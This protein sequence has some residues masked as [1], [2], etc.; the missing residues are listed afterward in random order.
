MRVLAAYISVILIWSTTPLAIKW[1]G[2]G[3][4]YLFGVTGRM[5]IGAIC[6]AMTLLLLRRRVV[7][8]RKARRTYLAVAVQIYAAM[9]VVY[10][11]SQYIPSGWIS[12]VFGCLG[13]RSLTFG[14]LLA[15][16]LGAGGLFVMFGTALQFGS[17]AAFGIG[18]VLLSALLQSASAVWIKRIDAKLPALSQVAGGLVFALPAYLLTWGLGDGHWPAILPESSWIAIL[19]L[20]IIATGAGF[21]LYYYVLL[22]LPATRV[23]LITLMSPVFA[24]FLGHA[25]NHEPL[26]PRI[27][28]GAALILSGLL[29]HEFSGRLKLKV[30]T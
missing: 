18:G 22:H 1:S 21:A 24:L 15:Y 27:I 11:A 19:Y 16:G 30:F 5:T 28:I 12:V 26:T 14:K 25:L 7:W 23:A 8:H 29:L 6:I 3:P 17:Q 10:W 4:G 9:L 2:E 20:G 13:E